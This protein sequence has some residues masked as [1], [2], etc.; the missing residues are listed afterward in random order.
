M[1]NEFLDAFLN[2]GFFL[3]HVT[4]VGQSVYRGIYFVEL[5]CDQIKGL[6][7]HQLFMITAQLWMHMCF[8]NYK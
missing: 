7:A 2:S 5:K 4:V 8:V 1:L 3:R 6:Y